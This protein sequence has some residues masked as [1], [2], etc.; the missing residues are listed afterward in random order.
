MTPALYFAV[1]D[2]I[3]VLV[4]DALFL[5]LPHLFRGGTIS[6]GIRR[7]AAGMPWVW[8]IGYIVLAVVLFV[9]L[10]LVKP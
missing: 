3:F 6:E 1:A 2:V 9:H 4:V 8:R 5:F 10:F 7:L